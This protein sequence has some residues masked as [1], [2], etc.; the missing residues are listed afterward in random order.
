MPK[1][2]RLLL[3]TFIALSFPIATYTYAA[4]SSPYIVQPGDYLYRIATQCGTTVAAIQAANGLTGTTIYVGQQL[5]IPSGT[6][7][8]GTAA[9]ASVAG[10]GTSTTTQTV[11]TPAGT[12]TVQ[13]GDTL[14]GIARKFGISISAL[15]SANGLT[16]SL[17]RVGQVLKI[18]GSVTTS[19]TTTTGTTVSAPQTGSSRTGGE[20]LLLANYFPGT[21]KDSGLKVRLGICRRSN[22]TRITRVP[23]NATSDGRSKRVWMVLRCIGIR[24]AIALTLILVKC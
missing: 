20:K 12:Y 2:I 9:G 19:P 24:R 16:G 15:Q 21:T 11:T 6:I 5:I 7:T 22:I 13:S 18:P 23:F 3:A 10:G 14:Y 8:S 4:C 17:I 1:W